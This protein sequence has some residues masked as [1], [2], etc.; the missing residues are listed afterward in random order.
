LIE[1]YEPAGGT[2]PGLR[3]SISSTLAA[4]GLAMAGAAGEQADP[5]PEEAL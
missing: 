4:A 3:E 5:V 2:I 1:A